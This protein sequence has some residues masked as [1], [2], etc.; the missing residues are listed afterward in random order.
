[1]IN[2]IYATNFSK[3]AQ[4]SSI[5]ENVKEYYGKVLESSSDLKTGN[6]V[7]NKNLSV[8]NKYI[9]RAISEVHQAVS[10]K[11]YGCGLCIPP[12]VEG[13]CILDLGSG[14]G[15]DCFAVSKLVGPDGSVVGIDMTKEQVDVANTYIEYHTERFGFKQPNVKF[16]EGYCED[17]IGAGLKKDSF[18][19][20]ISNC[21]INLCP[22]K[23]IVLRE[24]FNVLKPGGELYF[25]DMYTD[26]LQSD[27]VREDKVLWGEG[28]AGSLHWKQ[29]HDIT[30]K[31]GFSSPCIVSCSPIRVDREDFKKKLGEAKY[32]SVTYRLFK[33]IPTQPKD[34]DSLVQNGVGF[35]T[36]KGQIL[37]HEESFKFDHRL[38]LQKG[39]KTAVP[40][41]VILTLLSSRFSEEF[42]FET[43]AAGDKVS[44]CYT[45][46]VLEDPFDVLKKME[47]IDGPL[48]YC[49]KI[50]GT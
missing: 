6:E 14:S 36:Y 41:Q 46:R 50:K 15:R 8:E 5:L 47:E 2:Q 27:A 21:V 3:M 42:S 1:M 43:P 31:I 30:K 20:I 4:T 35:V 22:E 13:A 29:F 16:V 37:Y 48:K 12:G 10:A 25:S 44:C 18:D 32:C 23:E 24:A 49:Q 11:Y 45:W 34:I 19:I 38:T 17:L 7:C 28:F 40:V 9:C 39:V 33:P 26:T